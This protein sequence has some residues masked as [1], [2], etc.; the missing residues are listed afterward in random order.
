MIIFIPIFKGLFAW[1]SKDAF[2]ISKDQL[3]LSSF[4]PQGINNA[5][6]FLTF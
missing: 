4:Y 6:S 2:H 5:R 1:S 3:L